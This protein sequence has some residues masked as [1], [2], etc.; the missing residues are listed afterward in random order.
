MSEDPI[1]LVT[2][3]IREILQTA[4]SELDATEKHWR[5]TPPEAKLDADRLEAL[6]WT[7]YKSGK[8]DWLLWE[9]VEE[10]K[11]FKEALEKAPHGTLIV[12]AFRYRLQGDR[13]QFIAKYPESG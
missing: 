4:L 12:G 11:I 3:K 9:R 8:G 5:E 1:S 2:A 10:A 13:R 6:P 7:S